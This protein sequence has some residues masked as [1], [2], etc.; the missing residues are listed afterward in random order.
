MTTPLPIAPGRSCGSCTMCCKTMRVTELDKPRDKWCTHCDVGKGCRI[1]EE[2]PT[3]CREFVC[4]YLL[5]G[6]LGDHWKPS[7]ARMV[8][9]NRT[10]SV[11]RVLVDP[12]RPDTWRKQ[13]YYADL[14]KWA[15]NAVRQKSIVLIQ[16]GD[17][18]TAI[19]PDRD[20]AIGKLEPTQRMRLVARPGPRGPDYD[21]EVFDQP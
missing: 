12:D 11:L 19:L 15:A 16:V 18:M 9:S 2:R 7:H 6:T 5:D 4:V 14:K 17:L 13:P 3:S 1:Y 20:I 10:D 21:V 8:L